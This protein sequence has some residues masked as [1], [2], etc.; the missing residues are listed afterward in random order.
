MDRRRHAERRGHPHA[1]IARGERDRPGPTTPRGGRPPGRE[2]LGAATAYLHWSA[3]DGRSLA[4]LEAMACDVVVVA[5]DI[6]A[7]REVLSPE[8][9]CATEEGAAELLRAVVTD[10][11]ARERLLAGQR[12]RRD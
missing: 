6:A 11:D 7:N 8:Q 5:S 1:R 12:T 3:W 9:V 4:V 2:R 10:E